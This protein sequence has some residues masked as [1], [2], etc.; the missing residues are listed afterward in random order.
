MTEQLQH[1][2]KEIP[3]AAFSPHPWDSPGKNT[4]VGC[5][6]LLQCMKVKSASEVAVVSDSSRPHGLQPTRLLRPLDFPGESTGVGW[7]RRLRQPLKTPCECAVPF[8]PW[9]PGCSS[10]NC[11]QGGSTLPAQ[12]G[13][14]DHQSPSERPVCGLRVRMQC[15]RPKTHGLVSPG[16]SARP[17]HPGRHIP[18]AAKPLC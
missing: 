14:S 18:T 9:V 13:C 1:A 12:L 10:R 15:A 5:H 17:L 16:L 8:Q 3:I 11:P 2:N 6:F 7:H 4:G